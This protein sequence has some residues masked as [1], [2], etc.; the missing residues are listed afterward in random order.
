MSEF[1]VVSPLVLDFGGL[2]FWHQCKVI[3]KHQINDL[4]RGLI[5]IFGV[6][7]VPGML[8]FSFA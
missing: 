7:S 6:P 8:L 3:N 4:E 5:R 1:D 2:L